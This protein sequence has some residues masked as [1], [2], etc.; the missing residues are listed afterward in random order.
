MNNKKRLVIALATCLTA[1]VYGQTP[2]DGDWQLQSPSNT[3]ATLDEAVDTVVKEMN[4]FI[5]GFAR[6]ALEKEAVVCQQWQMQSDV[7]HFTWQCDDQA[8]VTISRIGAMSLKGDDD[9]TITATMRE[10]GGRVETTLVSER[11]KRTNIWQLN[12]SEE[13]AYTAVLE[14]EKLPKPLQWTLIYRRVTP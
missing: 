9:R 10:T 5:R 3:Q 11:G 8:P 7:K 6:S 1:S 13:L 4:F 12:S 2:I 14:S